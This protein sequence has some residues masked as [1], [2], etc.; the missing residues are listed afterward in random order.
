MKTYTWLLAAVLFCNAGIA[1]ANCYDACDPCSEC[2][3][4][5]DWSLNVSADY[6]YWKVNRSD[7]DLSDESGFI[8]PD[9]DHGFRIAAFLPT[10][11]WEVGARYTYFKTTHSIDE[12]KYGIDLDVV[13]LEARYTWTLD[14]ADVLFRPF[15]GT[16]LAWIVEKFDGNKNNYKGFGIYIGTESEWHVYD[17]CDTAISFV[18]RGAF[19]VMD[20]RHRTEIND[21]VKE[22]IF[23]PYY[24]VFA[25]VKLNMG[26]FCGFMSPDILIGY[27][28]QN[29]QDFR[30]FWN[31]N[32][33]ASMGLG[34]LVVRIGTEF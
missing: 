14:C 21:K 16:K 27:E 1:N 13:D 8:C 3:P 2:D 33:I 31:E 15:M 23:H 10:E 6:L 7:L 17:M 18:T 29:W 32:D 12:E 5:C 11:C 25:G 34:G 19:G 24:E 9:Y 26:E 22:C 20:G 30:E 4:C 28:A